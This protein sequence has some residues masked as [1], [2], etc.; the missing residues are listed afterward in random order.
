MARDQRTRIVRPWKEEE[1]GMS[2][3][4]GCVGQSVPLALVAI[5]LRQSR[6]QDPEPQG[7]RFSLGFEG[8]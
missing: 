4:R 5:T 3:W 8:K 2:P 1:A 7:P 6:S